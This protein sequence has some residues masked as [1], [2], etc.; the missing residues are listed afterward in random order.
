MAIKFSQSKHLLEINTSL[1]KDK[2]ILTHFSGTEAVS[3]LFCFQ[4]ELFSLDLSIDPQKLIGKPV[5]IKIS[6]P[7]G[8]IRYFHGIINRFYI[9]SYAVRTGRIYRATVVPWL[10]FLSCTTDRRIFQNRS[11]QEIIK[12]IFKELE[13]KDYSFKNAKNAQAKRPY[14]VQY[15][16]SSFNFISRLLEDRGIYYYFQHQQDKHILIL[17]DSMFGFMKQQEEIV[18]HNATFPE[19]CIGDWEQR[20]SCGTGKFT[21]NSYQFESPSSDLQKTSPTLTKFSSKKYEQ[22][23]YFGAAESDYNLL[24]AKLLMEAEDFQ[25]QVIEGK[26]YYPS[27]AAGTEIK[28]KQGELSNAENAYILLEVDHEVCDTSYVPDQNSQQS[29]HNRFVCIP[30]SILYRPPRK[31]LKPRIHGLQ[32]AL[33]MG[34][35]GEEIYTDKYGRIK[36]KFHWDRK[37]KDKKKEETSCWIRVVHS[38]SGKQWGTLFIPRVGQEVIISFLEGDPDQPLIMGSVYNAEQMPPYPLPDRRTQSGIRSHSTPK[39]SSEQV[40]ELRFEDRKDH[41]EIYCHAQ[42]DHNKIVENDDT[43]EIKN[44]QTIKVKK[45]R[46]ITVEEGREETVIKKGNYVLKIE[47][48]NLEETVQTGKRSTHISGDDTL[49]IEKGNQSTKLT[50]GKSELEAR[51][52]IEWKVGQN[53]IKIDPTGITLKGINLKLQGTLIEVKAD[54]S[55]KLQGLMVEGKGGAMLKLQGALTLIN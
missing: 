49:K 23:Y 3:K 8:S 33:V 4:L 32:T 50:M 43:T 39:G 40:N 34:P 55:L 18:F 41:E 10:W 44:N 5:S 24:Q 30:A 45:D 35:D 31:T 51:Q 7:T 28:F 48:G 29:Y 6:H 42:K 22:Y 25:S 9:G 53:S 47:Q 21:H 14:C 37:A 15:D 2:L 54:A 13:F 38:W 11:T 19:Q 46:L 12:E 17:S 27:F 36:V 1:G 52:S 16:E 20:Y 26:G